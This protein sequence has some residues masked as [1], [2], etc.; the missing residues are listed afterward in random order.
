MCKKQTSDSHSSTEAEVNSLDDGIPALD[1]WDLVL[2]VFHS[3]LNQ[4]NKTKDQKSQG[5]FVATHQTPLGKPK[6]NKARQSRL[7]QR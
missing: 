3:S 5:N 2:E 6:S 7:E 1:L 4:I